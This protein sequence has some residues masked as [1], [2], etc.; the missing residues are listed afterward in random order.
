MRDSFFSPITKSVLLCALRNP[1]EPLKGCAALCVGVEI[2]S[3]DNVSVAPDYDPSPFIVSGNIKRLLKIPRVLAT[4]FVECEQVV[5]A[6][7]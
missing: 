5:D 1:V 2:K 6:E 7:F 4:H 3:R